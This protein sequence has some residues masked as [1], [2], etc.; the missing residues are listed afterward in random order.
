MK[1]AANVSHIVFDERG[2]AWIKGAKVKVKEV[3]LDHLAHGWSADEIQEQ[4]PH[5]TLAQV[6]GAL[7]YYYDHAAEFAA[8]VAR[9]EKRLT[10]LRSQTESPALQR[11][12]RALARAS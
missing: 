7:A 9:D 1:V 11:R 3:V 2:V 5:L 10:K 12:L 6:H 4:H 8:E